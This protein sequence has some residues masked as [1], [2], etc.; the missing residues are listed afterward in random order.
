MGRKQSG[1]TKGNPGHENQIVLVR[2][3][4]KYRHDRLRT[5]RKLSARRDRCCFIDGV[6]VIFDVGFDPWWSYPYYPDD[7]LNSFG[8][9]FYGYDYSY[10]YDN[11][12]GYGDSDDTQR[13]MYYDQNSYSD[14]S[15]AYYDSMVYQ[16]EVDSGQNEDRDSLADA[17][18]VAARERLARQGYYRGEADGTFTPEMQ[19]AVKRYQMTNGLRATGHLDAQT[20]AV[21]EL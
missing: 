20:L 10:A 12:P 4:A 7:Y 21:M 5:S 6:W 1:N 18:V 15:Q 11:N 17:T 9:P 8:S 13:E 16:K 14:Q 2:S 3:Y 19:N